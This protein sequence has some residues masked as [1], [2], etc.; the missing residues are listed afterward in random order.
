MNSLFTVFILKMS[1]DYV[2]LRAKR[3]ATESLS[4]KRISHVQF[5]TFSKEE[6][7]RSSEFEV[8]TNKGYEQPS[9]TP[10]TGGVLD[11]RLGISDKHSACATCGLRL[12]DCPG[13]YGHIKLALPVFHVGYF[14][15]LI[16]VLQCICKTCSRVLLHGEKRAR[17]ARQLSHPLV[18]NDYVRRTAAMKRVV[19]TCKK[20]RECPH[21]GALN[22]IVKKV[23]SMR[24]LHEKFKEKDKSERFAST[25]NDF[26]ASFHAASQVLPLMSPDC[27]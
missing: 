11:R 18:L 4:G 27:T 20:E 26:K 9:R 19:E 14:K 5:G 16:A 13:H 15:P 22:G 8:I 10:V 17:F 23:G 2:P 12:Q 21:C 6:V 3:V 24:I 1:E 7:E 25:R